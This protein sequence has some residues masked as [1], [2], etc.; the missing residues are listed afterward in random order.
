MSSTARYMPILKW[1]QGEYQALLR[2]DDGVKD[3][4]LPLFVI[5]PV[6]Y[7]FEDEKPKKTVQEHISPFALRYKTK[8]GKRL[9]LIDLHESLELELMD[10]G[11]PVVEFVFESLHVEGLNAVPVAKLS[12]GDSYIESIKRISEKS[13][14]GAAFRVG[15]EHLM[16][17]SLDQELQALIKGVGLDRNEIDLIIDLGVPQKFEPYFAF[18]KALAAALNKVSGINEFRSFFVAGMSLNLSEIKKPGG[19]PVRHEWFLYQEI[20]K[21]LKGIRVPDYGDYTIENPEFISQDMRLLNPAGKVVY[22]TE[23]TWFI[24][25]GNSFRDNRAQM[26]SHCERVV[27]SGYFSGKDYSDGDKRIFN[28]ANYIEGTGNQ[29]TWKQAGVSHHIVFVV[30]QIARFHGP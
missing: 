15:F 24:P 5:P 21:C 17:P 18:A 20:V 1:R 4:I 12:H 25:K 2:L 29:G 28:T 13:Q 30:N 26:V 23:K 10:D 8:W 27:S 7:D 16:K 19:E 22:T 9:S 14:A 11:S 3:A 6:E